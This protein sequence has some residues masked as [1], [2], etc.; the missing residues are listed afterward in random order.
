MGVQAKAVFAGK[1][2]MMVYFAVCLMTVAVFVVQRR[3]D[4]QVR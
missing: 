3:A 1:Y 2:F 4:R